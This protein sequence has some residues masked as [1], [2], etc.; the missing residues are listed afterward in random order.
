MKK[1][2][3]LIFMSFFIEGCVSTHIFSRRNPDVLPVKYSIILVIANV[4]G[5]ELQT[6]LEDGLTY[7]LKADEAKPAFFHRRNKLLFQVEPL[8]PENIHDLIQKTSCDAVI[9]ISMDEP[10]T[11]DFNVDLGSTTTGSVTSSVF[12]GYRFTSK[13]TNQSIE[14]TITTFN[15][16][17]DLVDVSKGK[18]A[19]HSEESVTTGGFGTWDQAID[20][21]LVNVADQLSA[22]INIGEADINESLQL[23][24]VP[25]KT[26]G[27]GK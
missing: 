11:K 15:A 16:T 1:L 5:M 3:L 10:K 27:D 23:P 18:L 8:T 17:V 14:G 2:V 12:G 19:W 7:Y 21:F 20:N 25:L 9:F 4:P 26:I 22:S 13:T 24:Q 6:K